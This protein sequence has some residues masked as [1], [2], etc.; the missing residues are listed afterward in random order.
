MVLRW[1]VGLPIGRPLLGNGNGNGNANAKLQTANGKRAAGMLFTRHQTITINPMVVWF[2]REARRFR[3]WGRG[4]K[5][6]DAVKP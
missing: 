3:L 4:R 1:A 2:R 5:P 6:G